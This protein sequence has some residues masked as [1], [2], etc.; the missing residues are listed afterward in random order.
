MYGLLPVILYV[1]LMRTYNIGSD[2]MYHGALCG[3]F[4]ILAKF[5]N[6]VFKKMALYFLYILATADYLS[7]RR[8]FYSHI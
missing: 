6:I 3:I 8:L 1:S 7:I 5:L 4:L 2:T